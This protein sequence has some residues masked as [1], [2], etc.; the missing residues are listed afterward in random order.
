MAYIRSK[1]ATLYYEEY[2]TGEPLIL[3]TGLLGTIERHWRRFIPDFARQFHVIA[4]DLRG[5]GRT[6]NPSGTLRLHALVGDLFALYEALD[7]D[8]ARICGYSLGG[9]IG[10]AFGVQH[11]GRVHALMMHASKFY[12]TPTAAAAAA[13]DLDAELIMEKAPQWAK[14]LQADHAFGSEDAWRTLVHS[15]REFI[16]TLPAEGLSEHALRLADFPVLVTVGDADDMIPRGEAERLTAALPNGTLEILPETPHP[17]QRVKKEV[18]LN[19]AL[20]FFQNPWSLEEL[21]RKHSQR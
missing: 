8:S 4:V 11:P 1:D 9:Y 14:Q 5:H 3:L 13:E 7:L 19:R 15:A 20:M 16:G 6:D 10:L 21:V 12:W 17:L 2:G 18:V